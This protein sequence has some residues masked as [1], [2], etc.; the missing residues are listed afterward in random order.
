MVFCDLRA[1]PSQTAEPEE[2]M[3]VLRVS[4][5]SREQIV[6]YEGL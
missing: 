4:R 6:H 3:T 1:Q 2:V 5:L